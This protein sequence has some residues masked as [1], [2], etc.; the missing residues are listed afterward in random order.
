[1]SYVSYYTLLS[2]YKNLQVSS[3][4]FLDL[5]CVPEDHPDTVVSPTESQPAFWFTQWVKDSVHAV[6]DLEHNIFKLAR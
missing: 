3:E 6:A 4:I 2:H 1:M 5:F